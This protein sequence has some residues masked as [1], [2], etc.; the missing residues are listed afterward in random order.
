MPLWAATIFYT[1]WTTA[2]QGALGRA[3]GAITLPSSTAIGVSYT[4]DVESP[5]Q[6][7][8]GINYWSPSSPYLN[9]MVS[10][11]PSN[12]D[13]ISL[14]GGTG[15]TN[16]VTFSRPV[17][18]PIMLI[19][20][21]GQVSPSFLPV[22]Y[23]FNTPFTI[24]SS[25][26][27]YYGGSAGSLTQI[28]TRLEG[29]EGHG[30]IQFVGTVTS[31]S[32]TSNYEYWHGFTFGLTTNTPPIVSL[33]SPANGA[34]FTAGS[35]VTLSADARDTDGQIALVGLYTNDVRIAT[36]TNAPYS[37]ILSNVAVGTYTLTAKARDD[38]DAVTTSAPVT[39]TVI[40]GNKPPEVSITSPSNGAMFAAGA[41]IA[42]TANASDSDGQISLVGLYTNAV[43]VATFPNAPY[44]MVLSNVA[45]GT[46]ILTA[47]ARDNGDAVTTSEPVT[48]TVNPPPALTIN[49]AT[50]VEGTGGT[51]NAVFSLRLSSASSQAVSVDFSTANG[52]ALASSDYVNT[53]GTLVF[54]PGET[55]KTII[56][57]VIGDTLIEPIETFL[58]NLS[59]SVNATIAKSQGVGT[60]LNDDSNAPPGLSAIPN[61]TTREDTPTPAIAFTVSDAE[62]PATS[63]VV[64]ATSSNPGLVAQTGIAL[65]GSGSNRTITLTPTR[66]QF[67]VTTI[68][69]TAR[70]ADGLTVTN[71]FDLTVIPVNDPPTLD[72]ISNIT[73]DENS[74]PY[75]VKLTGISTGAP[76]EVQT[77]RVTVVPGNPFLI[78]LPAIDYTSPN[79]EGA[80][81]FIPVR[82]ATGTNTI[83]VT[84]DDGGPENATIL[85]TFIVVVRPTNRPP[86]ISPIDPQRVDEGAFLAFLVRAV[87]LDLPAQV[88]TYSLATNAP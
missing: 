31:I 66:D 56:V 32:W 42:I 67:G 44:R 55:N 36:F 34:T 46:Y 71:R 65:G 51:T 26:A 76:N 30:A 35:N 9:A 4:G 48:I 78:P 64:A 60:I 59:N 80:L 23:N 27:G 79:V 85:R 1:D 62:T 15:Y 84:V 58:V 10:N 40:P 21:L 54:N 38:A 3:A 43:S 87:D 14:Q 74:G 68:S 24:L 75:I 17:K 18:N 16:T 61:Q 28:G 12:T 52:T 2:S 8:G 53:S 49:D 20:S 88:L 45:V 70:D 22:S 19:V 25:G 57:S 5:T 47:K 37:V 7:N 11:V 72:P 13:I 63:L 39:I 81:R 82:N 83:T 29:K 6:I 69:L 86:T 73:V 41:N 77:L 50:V 33:T